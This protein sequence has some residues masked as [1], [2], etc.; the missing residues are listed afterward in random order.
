MT[1]PRVVRKPER[2][3]ANVVMSRGRNIGRGIEA[4]ST[5]VVGIWG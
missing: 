5:A 3:A 1:P 2:D 4:T